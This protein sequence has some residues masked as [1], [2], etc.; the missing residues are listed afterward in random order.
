V[1][2]SPKG[3]THRLNRTGI[4]G[5]GGFYAK[6]EAQMATLT[7]EIGS[8]GPDPA[9]LDFVARAGLVSG[10]ATARFERLPGGVSS[11]IWLVSCGSEAFCVK[12]A[13]PRLRVAADWRAPIERN[14]K[15]AAWIRAVSRFM[16]DAVPALLAEEPASGIFAMQFLPPQSYPGWKE[17]LRWG[18]VVPAAAAEVGRRLARIHGIMAKS[19]TATSEFAADAIFHALRLEPYLLATARAHPDR[20]AALQ[21]LAETT[22]RTKLTVIHGDVSPKNILVGPAGPVLID[23]ECACFGDPA[24]DLA[25]CLN[26]LLLKCLWVPAAAARLLLAF[27]TLSA[28]YLGAVNW[29]PADEIESRA[30]RLLPALFLARIDGKSPVEY[31]TEERDKDAVRGVARSLLARPP[32]RLAEIRQVWAGTINV[33]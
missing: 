29:E 4:I 3:I 24:F 30:A 14:A 8:G 10:S 7:G 20:A 28:T 13:L 21:S 27:D 15:E 5:D 22:A 32:T 1:K 25:F 26:H 23:A 6:G 31:L 18:H 9:I 33:V 12:R 17:Q 16:P 19:A 11:D 2:K